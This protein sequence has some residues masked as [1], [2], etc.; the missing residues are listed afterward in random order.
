MS[1]HIVNERFAAREIDVCFNLAMMTQVD[2]LYKDRHFEMSFVEFLEA[3]ARVAYMARVPEPDLSDEP[4]ASPQ[5]SSTEEL[6]LAKYIENVMPKLIVL[7][8][9]DIIENF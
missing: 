9:R 8:S 7:C 6:P 1:A 5:K 2:E 3:L 4:Q